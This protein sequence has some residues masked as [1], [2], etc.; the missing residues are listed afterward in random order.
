[1]KLKKIL[2]KTEKVKK[3]LES[4]LTQ[5]CFRMGISASYFSE[6]LSFTSLKRVI[7][8]PKKPYGD[9]KGVAH[10]PRVL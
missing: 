2:Q 4:F 8:G 6:Q 7:R 3:N 5:N 9:S 1:M 10:N